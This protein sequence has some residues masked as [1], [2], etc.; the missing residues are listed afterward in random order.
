MSNYVEYQT[1]IHAASDFEVM[2]ESTAELYAAVGFARRHDEIVAD[3][4]M[5]KYDNLI[6]MID[7]IDNPKPKLPSYEAWYLARYNRLPA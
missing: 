5:F 3:W 6:A 2:R 1:G 4:E 7:E